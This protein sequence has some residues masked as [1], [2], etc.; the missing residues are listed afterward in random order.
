LKDTVRKPNVRKGNRCW[1][2]LSIVSPSRQPTKADLL[3][4]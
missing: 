3:E 4:V 1:T 2:H